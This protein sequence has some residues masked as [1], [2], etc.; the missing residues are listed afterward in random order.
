M[1]STR[2]RTRKGTRKAKGVGFQAAL[3]EGHDGTCA[4]H[5]P[6]DPKEVWDHAPSEIV[7]GRKQTPRQAHLVRGTVNGV[8]FESAIWFYFRNFVM[9]IEPAVTK[10]AKVA[11]GDTLEIVVEPRA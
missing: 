11:P 10:R 6:F 3:Y 8:S 7:I 9:I 5:V 4:V 1:A 2:K